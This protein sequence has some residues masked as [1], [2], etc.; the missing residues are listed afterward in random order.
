[1]G[2]KPRGEDRY[3]RPCLQ[4]NLAGFFSFRAVPT[5]TTAS[6][7]TKEKTEKGSE[8][9]KVRQSCAESGNA[10]Q[11]VYV[12][13]SSHYRRVSTKQ[14]RFHPFLK[15]ENGKQ[16]EGPKDSRLT[17]TG[18]TVPPASY[19]HYRVSSTQGRALR[20]LTFGKEGVDQEVTVKFY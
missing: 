4:R 10:R 9:E 12:S 13:R 16:S 19:M 7:A 17:T 5:T 3:N 6:I 2:P 15:S 18:G 14:S 8:Q 11:E 20:I 1:V